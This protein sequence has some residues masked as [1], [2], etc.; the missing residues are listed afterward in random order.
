VKALPRVAD[1]GGPLDLFDL[2]ETLQIS[3]RTLLMTN[4]LIQY[5]LLGASQ[6]PS[7]V[8]NQSCR[9]TFISIRVNAA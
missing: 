1:R 8:E 5:V 6:V 4:T 2:N 7:F 9:H 3:F